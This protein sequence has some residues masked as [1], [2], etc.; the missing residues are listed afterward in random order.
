M[1]VD[2]LLITSQRAR[3]SAMFNGAN[4]IESLN[5]TPECNVLVIILDISPSLPL[6]LCVALFFVFPFSILSLSLH[7]SL[8]L[9]CFA[10]MLLGLDSISRLVIA[11]ISWNTRI[12]VPSCDAFLFSRTLKE[13][14]ENPDGFAFSGELHG[15]GV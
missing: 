12:S 8:S 6:S 4:T 11:C 3:I 1:A 5:D 13:Y 10:L 7:V 9:F 15:D 2:R 14:F